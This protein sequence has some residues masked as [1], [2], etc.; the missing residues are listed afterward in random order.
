MI[1]NIG[2]G[3]LS[4][5]I[6]LA[7]LC[8]TL[9]GAGTV[10]AEAD[11]EYAK[12]LLEREDPTFRTVD[13]VKHLIAQLEADPRTV[14]EANL[15]HALLDRH[16]ARTAT[17][18]TRA[19]FLADAEKQ[20]AKILTG[21]KTFAHYALAEREAGTLDYECA[22]ALKKS[23]T[24]EPANAA[25]YQREAAAL[26]AKIAEKYKAAADKAYPP[27]DRA[28][29]EIDAWIQKND[30]DM[31][32]KAV[33][34][35]L[36]AAAEKT[37]E[38]W[39]DP[40]QRYVVTLLDQLDCIPESDAARST[41]AADIVK[42]CEARSNN[43]HL[44]KQ[45]TTVA[46]YE[47]MAGKT[48]ALQGNSAEAETHWTEAW[49][50][51]ALQKAI[52]R[53]RIRLSMKLK[54]YADVIRRVEELDGELSQMLSDDAGK[55][56]L[57]TYT[58]A[59]T[60][61]PDAT[62]DDYQRSIR[63]LQTLIDHE[64]AG[65]AV[66]PW[67]NQFSAAMSE[68]V[69]AARQKMML[70]ALRPA[71]W[72][73]AA[74]GY[75][76]HADYEHARYTEGLRI[77]DLQRTE[78]DQPRAHLAIS[79]AEYE[80]AAECFRHA[81]TAAHSAPPA[82]RLSVEPKAWLQLG[83]CYLRTEDYGEALVAYRAFKSLYAPKNRTWLPDPAKSESRAFY[84][85]QVNASIADLGPMLEKS[86]A[87]AKYA[88]NE[89]VRRRILPRAIIDE[90]GSPSAD[91]D[92]Q[93]A[94]AEAKVAIDCLETAR[95]QLSSAPA[96]AAANFAQA[97][98]AYD[99]AAESFAKVKPAS[100][101]YET[102]LL[103]VARAYAAEQNLFATERLKDLKPEDQKKRA[104][105]Y[106]QKAL[107]AFQRYDDYIAQTA[108]A[109]DSITSEREKQRGSLLL[110]RSSLC[111][112][113]GAYAPALRHV[114]AYLT[115]Q[116]ANP[117]SQDGMDAALFNKFRA[118]IELAAGPAGPE[119]EKLFSDATDTMAAWH[120][121]KPAD[122]ATYGY[123]LTRLE[124][125]LEAIAAEA[126]TAK[127]ADAVASCYAKIAE[128]EEQRFA[129]YKAGEPTLKDFSYLLYALKRANQTAKA[130]DAG[131]KL[132]DTFDP[133]GTGVHIA[134][135]PAPWQ[136]L[137][138]RMIGDAN[139]GVK[140][141]I[142]FNDLNKWDRCKQDHTLLIDYM[143][144][145]PNAAQYPNG[146]AHRPAA[147]RF[148]MDMEKALAQ[149]QTIRRNYPDCATLKPE[150]GDNG[151][152]LLTI[153]EEEIDYRRKIAATRVLVIELATKQCEELD[154]AGKSDEAKAYRSL[155]SD[156]LQKEIDAGHDTDEIRLKK[157]GL[158][159]IL[160]K[161]EE[162]LTLLNALRNESPTDSTMYFDASK[163]RST[164]YAKQQK[165]RD[166]IEYPAFLEQ[167]VGYD[168]KM[169]TERWPEMK[170]FLKECR[171]HIK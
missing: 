165:W 59:L 54:K 1:K 148:N 94:R 140:G 156:L 19:K 49:R 160:E 92:F 21:P 46:W 82:M 163:L 70:P 98:E 126:A 151:K 23:A 45:E 169:V 132:L 75:E 8:A 11:Y 29:L 125:R 91:R 141:M 111:C 39:L 61:V 135:E 143:Y 138:T 64:S 10:R 78:R 81:I 137:L 107:D 101:D 66:S 25:Q 106:A 130:I 123:M 128:F 56:I 147:D 153:I 36:L 149:A 12:S 53:E 131:K 33:P 129:L 116:R 115:W 145:S 55:E 117:A 2:G 58:R 90:V 63:V 85:R 68:V 73:S 167:I 28:C 124:Q 16:E 104:H 161:Y 171:D 65:G 37:F 146:D 20:Y 154:R 62:A 22:R 108:A 9:L 119:Q 122:T 99:K 3:L 13:L 134:D 166:A 97:A 121:R 157:A 162:A 84:T 158:D 47:M 150:L 71:E 50:A 152:S 159:A 170:A 35:A 87:A 79:V 67:S 17:V 27:F 14:S 105:D 89:A 144:D 110:T 103:S 139:A 86:E 118:L 83:R 164:I 155:A 30:P 168:G 18:G 80:K 4:S 127:N 136:Q 52:T 48:F 112:A 32:G 114:E 109:T 60:L 31:E 6:P 93:R 44:F 133:K 5:R 57:E 43:D 74:T 113:V 120:A 77:T 24:E 34:P 72:F 51:P 100:P 76:L 42:I 41:F 15:I 88:L 102:A 7:V 95:K 96:D 26:F 38:T 40:D 69:T 142:R